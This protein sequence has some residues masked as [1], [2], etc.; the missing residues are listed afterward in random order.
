MNLGSQRGT[1]EE[2]VQPDV[3]DDFEIR[4]LLRHVSILGS[5][6]S[7]KTVM[8]KVILEEYNHCLSLGYY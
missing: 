2:N 5:S 8:A 7:G 4:H 6:G 1:L 3:I